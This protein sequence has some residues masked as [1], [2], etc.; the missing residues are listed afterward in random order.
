MILAHREYGNTGPIIII[1]H[2]LF[3]Q[4]DNWT[5]IARKLSNSTHIF[6]LD[7]RNHGM[8][9]HSDDFNY[10]VMAEDVIETM[11]SLKIEECHILGHSMGGKVAM[12]CGQIAPSRFQSLIIADIGPKYY[13]PH[14]QEI[15]KGLKSLNLETLSSRSEADEALKTYIP[16]F[17]TRQFLLKNLSRK[18]DNYFEWRFNL[19]SIAKNIEEIGSE[20]EN[21]IVKLPSLFYKGG[22]SRYILEEDKPAIL[23][24]F[25]NAVFKT[26]EGAG[27][28][29]HAENPEEMVITIL[30]WISEH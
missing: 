14:H 10:K 26:M 22:K 7:L 9:E 21:K 1:L 29:M 11:D 12:V 23:K 18:E 30:N 19:D 13:S 28:W 17:G 24:L 16:D 3:G 8:S 6:T 20:L 15:I 5:T 4:N 2:G 25:P 27:H